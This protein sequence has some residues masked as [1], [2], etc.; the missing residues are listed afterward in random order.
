V[1]HHQTFQNDKLLRPI[2]EYVDLLCK[3]FGLAKDQRHGYPGHPE[4]EAALLRL[5]SVT[6]DAKHFQ[7]AKYSINER[8]NPTG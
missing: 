1:A 8:G 3:T 5:H 2:L 7:L 6:E 4:I